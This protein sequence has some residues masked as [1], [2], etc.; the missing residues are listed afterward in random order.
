MGFELATRVVIKVASSNP[1]HEHEVGLQQTIIFLLMALFITAHT[2]NPFCRTFD[3]CLESDGIS[4]V[5]CF[6]YVD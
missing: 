6:L 4:I 5:P 3:L 1:V 2:S